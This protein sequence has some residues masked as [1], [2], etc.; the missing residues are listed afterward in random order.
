MKSFF[1]I[2]AGVLSAVSQASAAV[3]VCLAR[4]SFFILFLETKLKYTPS[5]LFIF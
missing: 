2:A 1:V 4:S 3:T 5:I